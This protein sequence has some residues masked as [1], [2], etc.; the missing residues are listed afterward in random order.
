MVGHHLTWIQNG[1]LKEYHHR[2]DFAKRLIYMM[3][4]V[5][6]QHSPLLHI[7]YGYVNNDQQRS[8]RRATITRIGNKLAASNIARLHDNSKEEVVAQVRLGLEEMH[9][10][11]R[12]GSLRFIH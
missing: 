11:G 6:T 9:T 1:I 3:K 4:K 12:V 8:G 5:Y 2:H 7:E 10:I